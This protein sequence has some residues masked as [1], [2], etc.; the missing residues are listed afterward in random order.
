[1]KLVLH[2]NDFSW[3]GGRF[4]PVIGAVPD[5]YRITPLEVIP[6]VADL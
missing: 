4:G 5:V 6:A 3:F 1:M 2:I